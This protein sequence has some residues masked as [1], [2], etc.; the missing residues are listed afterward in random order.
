MVGGSRR[1]RQTPRYLYSTC[2]SDM[3]TFRGLE[4]GFEHDMSAPM[5]TSITDRLY[6]RYARWLQRAGDTATRHGGRCE[7]CMTALTMLR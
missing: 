6:A 3:N 1:M 5:E 7:D 2:C 4:C